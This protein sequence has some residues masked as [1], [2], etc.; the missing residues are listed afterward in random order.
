MQAQSD[1]SVNVSFSAT[2]LHVCVVGVA[3]WAHAAAAPSATSIAQTTA[4]IAHLATASRMPRPTRARLDICHLG[5]A[6]GMSMFEPGDTQHDDI[7]RRRRRRSELCANCNTEVV[8]SLDLF[9]IHCAACV[10]SMRAEVEGDFGAG[11]PVQLLLARHRAFDDWLR[12][13]RG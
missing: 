5:N 9:G 2:A 7:G 8:S 10:V 1:G 3:A 11:G 6:R 12:R 13:N 4:G